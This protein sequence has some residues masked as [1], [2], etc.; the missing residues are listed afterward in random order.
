M[1]RWLRRIFAVSLVAMFVSWGLAIWAP[2]GDRWARTTFML[3]ILA[4]VSMSLL[5][6]V[7]AL[8]SVQD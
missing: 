5:V 1:I 3:F 7:A 2:I 6:V 8:K 4:V